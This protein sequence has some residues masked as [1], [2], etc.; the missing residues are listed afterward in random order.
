M[1][2]KVKILIA[3]NDEKVAKEVAKTI[4]TLN[5]VEIVGITENGEETYNKILELKPDIVFAKYDFEELD[6]LEIINKAEIKL[7]EKIPT[8]NLFIG[9]KEVPE[10]KLKKTIRNVGVKLNAFVRKPYISK[11]KDLIQEQV[12]NQ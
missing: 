8:F 7:K 11:V 9:E 2:N 5:Y 12:E 1:N 4:K 3:H 6:G 10:E